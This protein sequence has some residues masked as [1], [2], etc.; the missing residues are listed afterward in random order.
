MEA[1]NAVRLFSAW[2][3]ASRLAPASRACSTVWREASLLVSMALTAAS[4]WLCRCSIMVW[5]SAVDCAVRW[6]SRRT[7]SATTAK[8]RPCSP[9]RAASMAAFSA[10][11]L[12]CS[13]MERITSSTPPMRVLCP[14]RSR[15]TCTAWSMVSDS[16]SICA[17]LP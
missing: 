13:A 7:S 1:F 4:D 5:I 17:R 10:S 9:A 3:M 8:P 11:R 12:V 2:L 14:A 16:R 6:A 15:I